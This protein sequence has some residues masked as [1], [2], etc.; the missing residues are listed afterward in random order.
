MA[1]RKEEV[2][3]VRSFAGI[4]RFGREQ[5]KISIDKNT[6]IIISVGFSIAILALHLIFKYLI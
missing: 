4:F 6:L 2:A 1:A 3:P 5:S